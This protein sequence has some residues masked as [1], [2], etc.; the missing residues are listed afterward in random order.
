MPGYKVFLFPGNLTL[1]YIWHPLFTEE[2]GYWSK[3]ILLLLGQFVVVTVFT[4]VITATFRRW[5]PVH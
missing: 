4:A 1:I 3:L 2:L 5:F